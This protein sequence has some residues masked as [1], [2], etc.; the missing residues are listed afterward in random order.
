MAR[1]V[2]RLKTVFSV[3][4]NF[5]ATRDT[6]HFE[7]AIP[8]MQNQTMQSMSSSGRR[9]A[10]V[11]AVDSFSSITAFEPLHRTA[12]FDVT[13]S[14]RDGYE[15]VEAPKGKQPEV[16]IGLT[17]SGEFGPVLYLVVDDAHRGKVSWDHWEQGPA[18]TLAVFRFSV[19]EPE[20]H[21]FVTLPNGASTDTVHPA[22]HGE[23][24][25]DPDT[26]DIYRVTEVAEMQPPQEKVR[27]NLL[28]EYAPV[29]IGDRNYIC[30]VRGVAIIKVPISSAAQASDAQALQTY[31]NDEVFTQYHLFRGDTRIVPE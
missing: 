2:D 27:A 16:A 29:T 6:T 8:R 4:P 24:S 5:Y 1:A 20:S 7:D 3:L 11:I 17:T 19:T 10:G 28:V 9:G 14:Y 26:G 22:Y 23:I 25:V 31:L 21:F 12:R 18:G 15:V 13:V 30:P